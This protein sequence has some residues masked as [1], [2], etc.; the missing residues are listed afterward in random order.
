[1]TKEGCSKCDELKTYLKKRN[2]EYEVVNLSKKENRKAR[3]HYRN[4][5]YKLLPVIEGN[6]W[7]IDGFNKD[8]LE[9]LL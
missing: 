3:E 4:S 8:L 6:G 1:M 7:T 9:E 2:V 5:G